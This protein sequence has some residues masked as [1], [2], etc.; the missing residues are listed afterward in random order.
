MVVREVPGLLPKVSMLYVAGLFALVA[1]SVSFPFCTP[2][3]FLLFA[4]IVPFFVF[5]CLVISSVYVA[6]AVVVYRRLSRG[7]QRRK[8]AKGTLASGAEV[9]PTG[10]W[11]RWLD[12]VGG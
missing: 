1:G 11:D 8:P 12:G 10:V 4:W 9:R 2:L 6:G 7:T 5:A 3:L